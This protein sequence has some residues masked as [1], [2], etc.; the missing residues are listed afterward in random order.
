MLL[1]VTCVNIHF[2]FFKQ[3]TLHLLLFS[4]TRDKLC[5]MLIQLSVL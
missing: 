2:M 5:E 1:H 4:T 3:Q